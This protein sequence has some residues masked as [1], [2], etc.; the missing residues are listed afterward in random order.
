MLVMF[1]T[2]EPVELIA[3]VWF[4]EISILEQAYQIQMQPDE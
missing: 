3:C 1:V 4:F 2:S